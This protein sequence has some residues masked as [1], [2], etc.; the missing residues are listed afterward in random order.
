MRLLQDITLGN[1][2]PGDSPLHRLDARLKMAASL[3]LM[4]AGFALVSPGSV[5]LHTLAVLA[6]ARLSGIP[7]WAFLRGLRV[8]LWLFLFTAVLHLLF[9]PGEAL[10]RL[11]PLAVTRE[12][13][14]GGGLT[15]WRLLAA[16]ALSALLT[17]T[18][19]PL[20]ITRA[21]EW[22][23]EPFSPLLRRIGLP[24][25]DLSLMMMMALRFIPILAEEAQRVFLAQKAR[26]A[27]LA[28]GSLPSR[29]RSLLA[30]LLPLFAGVFRRADDLAL[31]LESRGFVPGRRRTSLHAFA[32]GGRESAGLLLSLLWL[33]SLAALR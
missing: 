9:T 22:F 16:I 27:D 5:L 31:A 24:V 8:F 2:I 20:E 33:A 28:H 14:A 19:T 30:L 32:W 1:Y 7:L 6:L 11:G 13:L 4:G 18:T 12:G 15:A 25:Q 17:H 21:L 29:A 3:V 26:G 10:L 23:A